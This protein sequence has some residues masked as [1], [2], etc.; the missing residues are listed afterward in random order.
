MPNLTSP[1]TSASAPFCASA[2]ASASASACA[3][4]STL[5]LSYW[6]IFSMPRSLANS[7]ETA[8]T[9][10]ALAIWGLPNGFDT[11]D[12]SDD[13]AGWDDC[14]DV[15]L[16]GAYVRE[17]AG[18]M[19]AAMAVWLRPSSVPIW[20]CCAV[21]RVRAILRRRSRGAKGGGGD[22]GQGGG[23]SRWAS[24][25][26]GLRRAMVWAC[27]AALPVGALVAGVGIATDSLWYGRLAAAPVGWLI[28]NGLRA[29]EAAVLF[30]AHPWHWYLTGGLWAVGALPI[31][32]MLLDVAQTARRKGGG[33]G[34]GNGGGNGDGGRRL[35]YAWGWSA[36]AAYVGALSMAP[37]KEDRF[38]MP[39]LPILHAYAAH[40]TAHLTATPRSY[41]A[42]EGGSGGSSGSSGSGSGSS[43]SGSGSGEA[44][45]RRHGN[46]LG[47]GRG[48]LCVAATLSLSVGWYL[49]RY[50]QAAPEQALHSLR[51][52]IRAA[53]DQ[54]VTGLAV[55]V[56]APC[57]STPGLAFMHV[58][59]GSAGDGGGG[60]GDSGG[61]G[62]GGTQEQWWVERGEVTA[63]AHPNN[64]VEMLQL[65]CVPRLAGLGQRDGGDTGGSGHNVVD[66]ANLTYPLL[67]DPSQVPLK[68]RVERLHAFWSREEEA[69]GGDGVGGG[70]AAPSSP[71]QAV[72]APLSAS[73]IFERD[74][75]GV[76]CALYTCDDVFHLEAID[77]DE[78]G[79]ANDAVG[80][81][82]P[83]APLP[84]FLLMWDSTLTP[85]R[86]PKPKPAFRAKGKYVAR[87]PRRGQ[88]RPAAASSGQT[89]ATDEGK[90]SATTNA[91]A[92]ATA[93]SE[94]QKIEAWLGARYE[95]L[96][97]TFHGHLAV[98][99]SA[100]LLLWKRK[101]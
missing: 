68:L 36:I 21:L 40:I 28:F 12:N 22:R 37:H 94:Q 65:E 91:T 4:R 64:G 99:G 23:G 19:A 26:R 67:K 3:I 76:I 50:H 95:L 24:A 75:L 100:N 97:T 8:L 46:N 70:G 58:S 90:A 42:D 55:H 61:D 39:I 41:G 60:R 83:K 18:L 49:A 62:G 85:P 59:A 101:V 66:G 34:G 93:T 79:G 63:A 74:P 51:G 38:L 10:F 92:N 44:S 80:T 29:A 25:R 57:Y 17:L 11:P 71:A 78:A 14:G 81:T 77:A 15:S 43:G 16:G 87:I 20:A 27:R 48:L 32:A 54:G 9:A 98:T 7:W 88:K 5:Q 1:V 96:E 30:G 73:A 56:L 35:S 6:G 53:T 52:H 33:R 72:A 86:V 13:G 84:A 89:V 69:G 82:L 47:L 2:S 45:H 31:L